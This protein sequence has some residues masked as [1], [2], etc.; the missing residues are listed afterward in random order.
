MRW[1][2]VR[3]VMTVPLG[4]RAFRPTHDL[5]IESKTPIAVGFFKQA[6]GAP[7]ALFVNRD[8][9]SVANVKIFAPDT[10]V[11][12]AR[13]PGLYRLL[14]AKPSI[15]AIQNDLILGPGDAELL[16]LPSSFDYLT[17]Q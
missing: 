6:S 3:H 13:A 2:G 5:R 10:L 15:D 14:G 7:Y 16:R 4:C 12:W 1:L 8:Y 17:T 11:R 9:K